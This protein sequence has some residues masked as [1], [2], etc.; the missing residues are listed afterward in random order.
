[1]PSVAASSTTSRVIWRA[2]DS[3]RPLPL[4]KTKT[5]S[6]VLARYANDPVKAKHMEE[7]RK[8]VAQTVYK[9]EP[10]TLSALRLGCGFSQAQLAA[11]VETTQPYIARVERGQVDPSTDMIARL[12]KALNVDEATAF[13][14]I[15]NQLKTR[16]QE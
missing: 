4:P 3:Q 6:S 11:L 14:A 9:D 12:A 16:G 5:L 10:D 13:R 1:M 7:A 2:F 8:V 15:R